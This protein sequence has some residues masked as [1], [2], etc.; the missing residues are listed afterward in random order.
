[1][2]GTARVYRFAVQEINDDN[3]LFYWLNSIT[4][5]VYIAILVV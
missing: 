4:K 2:T 1:M 5:S 3:H